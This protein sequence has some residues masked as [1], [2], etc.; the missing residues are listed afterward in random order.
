MKNTNDIEQSLGNLQM[1]TRATLDEQIMTD[2]SQALA[3]SSKERPA[4]KQTGLWIRRT[5]MKST[6]S[7]LA[8]SA[9]V[10]IVVVILGVIVLEKSPT[11]A[12]ALEQTVQA[13]R[14]LR[15]VPAKNVSP[16]AAGPQETWL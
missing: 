7:K 4:A 2:A 1:R 5:I 16:P 11:E 3:Q 6:W 14:G 8:T 15:Y 13:N 10:I 12:Y 9:A